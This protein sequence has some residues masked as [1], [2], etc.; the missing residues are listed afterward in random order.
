[1]TLTP[2]FYGRWDERARAVQSAQE[3]QR[4]PAAAALFGAGG[5]FDPPATRAAVAAFPP[6]VLL[7]AGEVDVNSPPEAMVRVAELFA[8]CQ[9]VIQRAA[10]H[11]P[12][13]DDAE[14]FLSSTTSYLR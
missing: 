8:H 14:Q 6:A 4:N 10:G 5:A 9:L 3:A 1:M 11:F 7:L 12:W 13:L 2:F